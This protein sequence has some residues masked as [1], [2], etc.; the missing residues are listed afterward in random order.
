MR[1]EEVLVPIDFSQHSLRALEFALSSISPE[2][3]ICLLHVLEAEFL[4]RVAVEGLGEREAVLGML[5]QRAEERLGE[6]VA[7]IPEPRPTISSMVVVGSPFQEILRVASD[8]DYPMIVLGKG[9]DLEEMLFRATAEKV[10][11]A[12]RIP[13][14]TVPAG[15]TGASRTTSEE[16]GAH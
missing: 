3:E 7:A 9:R 5:R 12:A 2:G 13:V 4:E 1:I 6:V 8:L 11:R 16:G 15:W 10:I 14:V